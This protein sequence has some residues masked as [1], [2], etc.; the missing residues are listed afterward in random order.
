MHHTPG[1]LQWAAITAAFACVV[2]A[3]GNGTSPQPAPG[4]HR[5]LWQSSAYGLILGA[6]LV[7][8]SFSALAQSDLSQ[9]AGAGA[10]HLALYGNWYYC[11]LYATLGISILVDRL[12]TRRRPASLWAMAILGLLAGAGSLG[13]MYCLGFAAELGGSIMY[14]LC[15]A[16]G[17][18]VA[19][20]ASVAFFR[21]KLTLRWIATILLGITAV[22]LGTP[23]Q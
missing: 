6:L 8:N 1:V 17:I 20:A 11:L 14:A 3:S 7:M 9:R 2:T 13:G 4:K 10:T 5:N 18:V 12:I 23:R 22:W 16:A 15:G 21:E 19:S